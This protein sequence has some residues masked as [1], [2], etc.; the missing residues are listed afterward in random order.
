MIAAA[1]KTKKITIATVKAFVRK[2]K[3][4]GTLLVRCDSSFDGMSDCVERNS[5]AKFFV[6]QEVG[7]H[8]NNLGL[9]GVY[10][11]NGS[12][13]WCKAYDDGTYAGFQVSNCCG[14][15]VVATL[16]PTVSTAEKNAAISR[17]ILAKVAS[18][19]SLEFAFDAVLGVGRYEALVSDLYDSFRATA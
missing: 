5:D 6:P 13:N 15:W 4:A 8:G 12:G 1:T 18:G 9:Q 2:A 10:F 11:V 14:S 3:A 7:D 17:M 16:K 19:M